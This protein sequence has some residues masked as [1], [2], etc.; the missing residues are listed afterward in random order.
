[1]IAGGHRDCPGCGPQAGEPTAPTARAAQ[2]T[3]S[4]TTSTITLV[5]HG[6]FVSLKATASDGRGGAVSQQII[7]A[8]GLK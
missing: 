4:A 1:V 5:T 3:P 8:F 2:A 7:R 6:G